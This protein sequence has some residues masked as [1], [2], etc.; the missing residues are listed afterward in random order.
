MVSDPRGIL[1]LWK[2]G[3]I[4]IKAVNGVR[5]VNLRVS[6]APSAI[7]WAPY[8]DDKGSVF[9]TSDVRN[10]ILPIWVDAKSQ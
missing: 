10:S 8:R 2:S 1:I 6:D 5:V 4:T 3:Y 9:L 7:H